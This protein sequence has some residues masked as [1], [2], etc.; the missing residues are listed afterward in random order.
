MRVNLVVDDSGIAVD[1]MGDLVHG[2]EI[3]GQVLGRSL[4]VGIELVEGVAGSLVLGELQGVAV[5]HVDSHV[6]TQEVYV[7]EV[8]EVLILVDQHVLHVEKSALSRQSLVH[9][10]HV[11]QQVVGQSV[12]GLHSILVLHMAHWVQH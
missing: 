3:V 12:D 2:E 7:C 9:G 11:L 5:E 6:G 10:G 4:E 8:A 1:H